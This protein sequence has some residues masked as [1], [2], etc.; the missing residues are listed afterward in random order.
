MLLSVTLDD[1][2]GVA[3]ERL[4]QEPDVVLVVGDRE[5]IEPGLSSLGLAVIPVDAEGRR[6]H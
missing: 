2:R 1:V 5:T 4:R 6:L 3:L